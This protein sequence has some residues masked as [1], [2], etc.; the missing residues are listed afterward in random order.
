MKNENL[1]QSLKIKA[2]VKSHY[3]ILGWRKV[4]WAECSKIFA[5]IQMLETQFE[6][7]FKH[8]S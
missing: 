8:V 2:F 3:L 1:K 4:C 7:V 5:K 6:R